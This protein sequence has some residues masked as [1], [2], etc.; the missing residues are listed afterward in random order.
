MFV[1]IY[2]YILTT[3]LQFYEAAAHIMIYYIKNKVLL[4]KMNVLK[5][6]IIGKLFICLQCH[7][8]WQDQKHALKPDV[9]ILLY[10]M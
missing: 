6:L 1:N 5:P 10:R 3:Y 7:K 4:I 8:T 2:I 9:D